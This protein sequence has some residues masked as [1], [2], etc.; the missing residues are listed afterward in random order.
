VA[1]AFCLAFFLLSVPGEA[2]RT[3]PNSFEPSFDGPIAGPADLAQTAPWGR[4]LPFFSKA[5]IEALSSGSPHDYDDHTKRFCIYDGPARLFHQNRGKGHARAHTFQGLWTDPVTGIAYARNRW[6]DARTASWLSEDSL[7]AIDSSNLYAFVG[8]GPHAGRDPMGLGT[9]REGTLPDWF[10]TPIG[11][12]KRAIGRASEGVRPQLAELDRAAS[13]INWWTEHTVGTGVDIAVGTYGFYWWTGSGY[14]TEDD[15]WLHTKNIAS[16]LVGRREFN[17]GIDLV[18][19]GYLDGNWEKVAEGTSY[20]GGSLSKSIGTGLFLYQGGGLAVNKARG[21][22]LL[23]RPVEVMR[24]GPP[25]KPIDATRPRHGTPEHDATAFN[26][27]RDFELA[28]DTVEARFNQQLVGPEGTKLS[29]LTPDAQRI[30]TDLRVD[31]YEVQ[32]PSQSRSFMNRKMS[33]YREIL[34]DSAGEVWW[35]EPSAAQ[36]QYELFGR[37]PSATDGEFKLFG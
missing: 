13:Q 25:R 17:L 9:C 35:E 37:V 11:A 33:R 29:N 34:G 26:Q 22:R 10:C 18:A 5:D 8:W 3:I 36:R 2:S 6:Y 14:V 27:A 15:K 24:S 4:A 1:V 20:L 32:S 28:P 16:E 12:V 21:F 23:R 7:G 19:E 30:R 31:V